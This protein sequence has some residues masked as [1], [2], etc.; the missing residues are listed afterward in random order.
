[1]PATVI[2]TF[3]E[4]RRTHLSQVVS[5]TGSGLFFAARCDAM[6][7]RVEQKRARWERLA[8][9]GSGHHAQVTFSFSMAPS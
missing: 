6:R 9:S 3:V 5:S 7:Q 4:E 2:G 8:F 1:M